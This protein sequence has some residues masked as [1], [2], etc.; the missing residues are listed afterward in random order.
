MAIDT[1][2][3]RQ[4][5]KF[6]REREQPFYDL[7]A[8]VRPADG[9]RAVD[10]GCGT[11]KLTRVLHQRVNARETTGIDR[12]DGMLAETREGPLPAGL[13][14]RV[15]TIEEF[16]GL[17]SA[18]AGPAAPAGAHADFDLIFSNAAF[19][20]VEHHETLIAALAARL[21]PAGQLAFQIPAQ[22][23]DASHLIAEEL[24]AVE[25]FQTALAGWHRP[26]PV[27]SAEG[28]ARLLYKYGFV[29]TNVRLIV[30][31]HILAGRDEVVEW[32]KGTLLTE[33]AR[34]LSAELFDRFLGEYR[35]RLLAR[36][37]A[38]Q[39][40]FFPFKRILCWGQQPA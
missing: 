1:W 39:P 16:A 10:L 18:A 22:H 12:S 11:G 21:G 35:S 38:A 30:Y 23:E 15:G 27:L 20:W 5:D 28:Y 17:G 33:Y 34:H 4:Y 7:L 9:M 14:F 25:P 31:P 26:Q 6:Q 2:D 36:L 24:T 32:M 3:P 29:D 19:H 8:M 37:D 13:R 40:F